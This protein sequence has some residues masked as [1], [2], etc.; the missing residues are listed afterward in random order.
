MR[1]I[2]VHEFGDPDVMVIGEV[3]RPHPGPG[4]ALVRV[5]AAGVN[6]VETYV[7]SGVYAALPALPYTPGTDAAGTVE[8]NGPAGGESDGATR[9]PAAG[10]R[11]YTAG[12]LSG[13]Y[14]E[15]A[16]CRLDQLHP[17]PDVLSYAQGAALGTPY[18]TAHLALFSRG[19][20]VAGETVLVHGGSGTVGLAAIQFALGAGLRVIATAGSDA[21]RRLVAAQGVEQVFDHHDAGHRDA[22][23]DV[24]DG[25]GVDL[26]VELLA[27][28]NLG[29]DLPLLARH[30]RV[31]VVGSRGTVE[32]N[33]RDLM[34]RDASIVGMLVG[35]ARPDELV[36]AHDAVHAGVLDGTLRPA[37][38]R[39][40]P[41]AEAPRAHREV[42]AGPAAGRIV[43]APWP[44]AGVR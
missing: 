11:V 20:A 42:I 43:L 25:R 31:V 22:V 37:V 1:A 28:V 2:R 33:P 16:L 26:I 44:P 10:D 35:N 14:A 21:G 40:L 19:R 7:R 23:L 41:L 13:T 36:R 3:E 32:V 8:E 38:A 39:E 29:R 24:T 27:N 15:Y 30:G 12:S 18:V 17:L 4:E 9:P 6:P 34:S 5:H